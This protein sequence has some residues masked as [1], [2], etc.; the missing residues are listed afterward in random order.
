MN[1]QMEWDNDKVLVKCVTAHVPSDWLWVISRQWYLTDK[2][3]SSL[4]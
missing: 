3:L 4:M 2:H 1:S